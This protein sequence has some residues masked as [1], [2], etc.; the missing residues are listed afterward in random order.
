MGVV[1]RTPVVRID[2]A[3]VPEFR[4]LIEVRDAGRGDLDQHLREGV[5][6]PHRNDDR[7]NKGDEAL[8]ER[9]RPSAI[10]NGVNKLLHRGI[11]EMIGIHPARMDLCFMQGFVHIRLD[12]IAEDSIRTFVRQV[13]RPRA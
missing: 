3:K 8:E 7:L 4:P 10:E 9:V 1:N 2:E 13:Q 12:A 11:I 5:A 6:E